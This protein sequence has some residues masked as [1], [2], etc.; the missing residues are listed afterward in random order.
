M[1]FQSF[2]ICVPI[3][4]TSILSAPLPNGPQPGESSYFS[5]YDGKS[6]AYPAN[7]TKDAILP[8]TN[9]TPGLDDLLF[10]NL[11]S[12]EWAIYSFYQQGVE[13]FNISAFV[14][15]GFL[16]TTYDR[17]VEIRDNEAGHLAIFQD[18]ISSSSVKPG[19]CHYNFGFT[20]PASY[21]YT[22]TLLEISSMAFLTGLI[23]EA[24]LDVS[25]SA[26]VAIA[27]TESR[28]NTWS[29]IDVWNLD[30]FVGPADTAFP[31]ANQ[32]LQSTN[33]FI[34]PGSCPSANPPYPSPNQNLPTLSYNSTNIEPGSNI[35]FTFPNTADQPQFDPKKQYYSVA[36]HA[37]SNFSVPY[38]VATQTSSIPDTI[39]SGMGLILLVI[40]DREGAPTE[41]SVVAGP[42]V[43]LSQPAA[44]SL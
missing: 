19:D 34:I 3:F 1:H 8:T 5:T 22:A 30:P 15:A 36:F 38:D 12:A 41:E 7:V 13:L 42:L 33:L 10:Q 39:E 6:D 32:I 26:L 16:N 23:L 35:T 28:H 40:A 25:K 4:L 11:L 31:Y 43:L 29:L 17:L 21:L 14:T 9:G 2:I 20:D 18:Q 24:D 37:L 27:E 44:G